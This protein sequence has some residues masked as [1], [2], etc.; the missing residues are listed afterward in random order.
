MYDNGTLILREIQKVAD[1]GIYTCTTS[2]S[3]PENSERKSV[4]KIFSFRVIILGQLFY[5]FLHILNL[6]DYF[7]LTLYYTLTSI[8]L[9]FHYPPFQFE[10]KNLSSYIFLTPFR[11]FTPMNLITND[12]SILWIQES[13]NNECSLFLS[14]LTF[15]FPSSP[16]DKNFTPFLGHKIHSSS[17]YFTYIY[18]IT[19]MC[20]WYTLHSF[21]S[22]IHISVY[23]LIM[24]LVGGG[25]NKWI[26]T[27]RIQ[28]KTAFVNCWSFSLHLKPGWNKT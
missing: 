18:P 5:H 1:D 9:S 25:V 24:V 15:P 7:Y 26:T 8:H 21:S 23:V 13:Y 3:Y 20:V 12:D 28:R 10:S 4:S 11:F 22:T 27:Q 19:S 16:F 17:F 2:N 6:Y 14:P